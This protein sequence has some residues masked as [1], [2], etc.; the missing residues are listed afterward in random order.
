MRPLGSVSGA[1][2]FVCE[3]ARM[4]SR[5]SR[6]LGSQAFAGGAA[7]PLTF[8]LVKAGL[9]RSEGAALGV[10]LVEVGEAMS[11]E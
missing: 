1:L 9:P 6:C 2:N 5:V 11:A 4:A 7:D 10:A 3:S 8:G